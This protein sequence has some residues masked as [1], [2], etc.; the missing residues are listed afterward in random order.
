[1]KTFTLTATSL[2]ACCFLIFAPS[3]ALSESKLPIG[4]TV[5]YKDGDTRGYVITPDGRRVVVR[6]TDYDQWWLAKSD[7]EQSKW[8]DLW[9]EIVEPMAPDLSP[10]LTFVQFMTMVMNTKLELSDLGAGDAERIK[11]RTIP[12]SA[13]ESAKLRCINYR[14]GMSFDEGRDQAQQELSNQSQQEQK[15]ALTLGSPEGKPTII[16]LLKYSVDVSVAVDRECE[17]EASYAYGKGS[18]YD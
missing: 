5:N 2:A 6:F 13:V 11:D 10:G 15:Q 17:K 4:S 1:M 8:L 18:A 14:K 3:T 12:S 9:H 7:E 16:G